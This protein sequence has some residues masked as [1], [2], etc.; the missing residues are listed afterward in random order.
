MKIFLEVNLV[1]SSIIFIK[2]FIFHF[3]HIF[4]IPFSDYQYYIDWLTNSH[5]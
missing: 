1:T 5:S 4:L 3:F 2:S